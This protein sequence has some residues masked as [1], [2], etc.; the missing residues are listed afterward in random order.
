MYGNTIFLFPVMFHCYTRKYN[1]IVTYSYESY[2]NIVVVKLVPYV[3]LYQI[4]FSLQRK[5]LASSKADAIF[6]P[7]VIHKSFSV[8]AALSL[9]P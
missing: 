2:F 8:D 3:G 1:T 9:H 5:T 6:F 7:L 4:I